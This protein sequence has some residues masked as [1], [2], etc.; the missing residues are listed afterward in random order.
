LR[1]TSGCA[2]DSL[3][4]SGPVALGSSNTLLCCCNGACYLIG[5]LPLP[6]PAASPSGRGHGG[7]SRARSWSLAPQWAGRQRP[8]AESPCPAL[9][10]SLCTAALVLPSCSRQAAVGTGPSCW[11]LTVVLRRDPRETQALGAISR[12]SEPVSLALFVRSSHNSVGDRGGNR[13]KSLHL[14]VSILP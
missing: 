3:F 14:A 12:C 9:A 10:S 5:C 2:V 8:W 1:K 6:H 7:H 11:A 13:A 4:V